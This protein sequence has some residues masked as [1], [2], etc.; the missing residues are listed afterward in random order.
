MEGEATTGSRRRP[1]RWELRC[2]RIS[3]VVYWW[4]T[5]SCTPSLPRRAAL[6]PSRNLLSDRKSRSPFVEEGWATGATPRVLAGQAKVLGR[7][8]VGGGGHSSTTAMWENRR[9]KIPRFLPPA[10]IWRKGMWT[11]T[12]RKLSFGAMP[13][14]PPHPRLGVAGAGWGRPPPRPLVAHCP[15]T[16]LWGHELGATPLVG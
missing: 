3:W 7:L 8:G 10:W 14:P 6:V 15:E 1:L 9:A 2:L 12:A 4:R 11:S 5:T 16:K 13:R